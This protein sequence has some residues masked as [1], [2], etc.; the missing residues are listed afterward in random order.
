MLLSIRWIQLWRKNDSSSKLEVIAELREFT[1]ERKHR[2]LCERTT[3][4][5]PF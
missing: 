2:K 4:V 3:P 5:M 1:V